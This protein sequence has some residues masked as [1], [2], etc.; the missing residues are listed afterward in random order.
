MEEYY[1]LDNGISSFKVIINDQEVVKESISWSSY[2]TNINKCSLR[3]LDNRNIHVYS[4]DYENE[5]D[6]YLFSIINPKDIFVSRAIR[7]Y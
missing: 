2:D 7:N 6:K 3:N 1:I 5:T 4:R